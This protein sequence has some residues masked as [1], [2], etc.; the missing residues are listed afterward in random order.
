MIKPTIKP[1]NNPAKVQIQACQWYLSTMAR[2]TSLSGKVNQPANQRAGI[3]KS[4]ET[5]N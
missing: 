1:V 4:V 5:N 3:N 2:P